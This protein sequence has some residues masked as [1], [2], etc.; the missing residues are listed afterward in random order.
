[1]NTRSIRFRLAAW[2]AALLALVFALLGGLLYVSVERYLHET[3]LATQ[4][5]RARQIAATLLDRVPQTGEQHVVRQLEALYSPEVAN[6][7]IRVSRRSGSVLYLSGRPDDQSFMPADVP[8]APAI[9]AHEFSRVQPLHGF[10]PLLVSAC[11]STGPDPYLVEVGTSAEPA[12]R[13]ARHLLV[14]LGIGVP[15]LAA[16]A[17]AGGYGL[18][19]RAL[20]PVDAIIGKAEKITQHNLGERLPATD[21][22]DELER[23]STAL[24]LMISRLDDAFANSKRFVADASHELRTPLT[25][26]QGELEAMAGEPHLALGLKER[27]GSLLEEVERLAQIVQ[28]LFALSRLDAGE[29]QEEWVRLDVGALAKATADQMMLLAEDRNIR[30][31][32]EIAKR[33]FVMGDR[34]RLKQVVVNLLD[35]AVKFTS[36][37]GTVTLTVSSN[38]G[39]AVIEVA[40]TGIGI[41]GEAR[42]LVFERF[43]RA[44]R[45]RSSSDGGAGLGLAI[46]KSICVAHGGKVEVESMVGQGSHF[47]VT[48]PLAPGP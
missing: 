46:V 2:H 41:S 34:P 37:G 43:F 17:A 23:L 22:G 25:I 24:N 9:S 19:R 1:M 27:I 40:D 3:L 15:L 48:L 14:L 32:F 36:P 29:A 30:V 4:A 18:V 31:E 42:L 38:T 33:V 13:F 28:K 45:G 35:N 12:D 26:I 39:S 7:F 47:Y 11:W 21:T 44:D 10:D 20:R 8:S 5:R 6:R 16:V